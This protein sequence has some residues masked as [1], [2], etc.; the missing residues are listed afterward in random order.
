MKSQFLAAAA[1]RGNSTKRTSKNV[2]LPAPI[3]GWVTAEGLAS[4]S[5]GTAQ[6]LDNI[7]PT[8]TGVRLRG[9]SK[10]HATV[11]LAGLPVISMMSFNAAG[12]KKMF[13][14]TATAIFDI[15]TVVDPS[16]QV[17]AAVT[18]Q[19]S[20]YYSFS[21][22]TTSGG[23]FLT[24]VNGTD[25]LRLYDPTNGWRAITG[26]STPAITGAPTNTLSHV[27]VYRTRQFFIQAGTLKAYALPVASIAGALI[28]I[29]LN[30]VFQ[31]GGSLLFG[32]TWSMDT[33]DGLDDKCVFVTDQGEMA[34]FEGSNPASTEAAQWNLVGRYDI[35][36]PMGKRATMRAGG[37]LLIA[38]EE[39]IV[40]TTAAVSKDAAAL[41]MASITRPITPDWKREA[42]NRRSLPWE[43]IKWPAMSYAIVSLPI[44]TPGQEPI[45]FVVNTETGAWCR[46]RNW[47]I[48]CMVLHD[49]R[50]YFGTNDGRVKLAEIGGNDDGAGIYYTCVSKDR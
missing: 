2:S 8:T 3:K 36:P 14:A 11:S 28:T 42:V 40:P 12:A 45:A 21:N 34:V 31:R 9:G 47:D 37:D 26:T 1:K 4:T 20:G 5:K 17:A 7:L 10:T 49:N 30:G 13:A 43:I 33:G 41:S 29:D 50:L 16:A 46:Y 24:A 48:R 6:T 39:G 23:S 27:W 22:F 19:T 38:C 15:T 35:T 25:S 32:D 18:G 44:T